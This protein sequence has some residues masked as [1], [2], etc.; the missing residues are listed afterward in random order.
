[1]LKAAMVQVNGVRKNQAP[2]FSIAS[3]RF[4]GPRRAHSNCPGRNR[5][6][7][8][9]PYLQRVSRGNYVVNPN[10]PLRYANPNANQDVNQP[11]GDIWGH[12]SNL[13]DI[14]HCIERR[15][16]SCHEEEI[17]H[18]Q[19]YDAEW[20]NTDAAFEPME[21]ANSGNAAVP[22]AANADWPAAGVAVP[23]AASNAH[24]RY[25]WSMSL[26]SEAAGHLVARQFQDL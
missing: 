12:L 6:H 5:L 25:R 10:E 24:R 21:P 16:N 20:G 7:V 13:H 23:Q 22:A 8:G 2:S 9:A 15:C 26:H 17:I 19:E 14:R 11:V 4:A 1:M 18:R 3:N